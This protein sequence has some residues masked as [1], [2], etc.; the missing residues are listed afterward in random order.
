MLMGQG[1]LCSEVGDKEFLL[2][3]SEGTAVSRDGW[4]LQ[5]Q[6]WRR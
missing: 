2:S 3:S 4:T 1:D 6:G 5:K